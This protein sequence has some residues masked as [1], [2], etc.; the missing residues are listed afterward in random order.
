MLPI[1]DFG[2]KRSIG[3]DY[4]VCSNRWCCKKRFAP[5]PVAEQP[6]TYGYVSEAQLYGGVSAPYAQPMSNV[7][8][9]VY[10]NQGRGV[11]VTDVTQTSEFPFSLVS[12]PIFQPSIHFS[13]VFPKNPNLKKCRPLQSLNI[14]HSLFS[15]ISQFANVR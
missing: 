4:L 15:S 5:A 2:G 11:G 10:L 12:K 14:S 13:N 1:D 6:M 8:F 7:H 3:A 9:A